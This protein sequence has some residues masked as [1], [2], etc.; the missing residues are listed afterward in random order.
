MARMMAEMMVWA[1]MMVKRG[2]GG[3]GVALVK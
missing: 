1:A 2:F 3:V